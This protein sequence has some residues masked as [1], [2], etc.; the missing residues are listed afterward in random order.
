M[1]S[2]TT[3][4]LVLFANKEFSLASIQ[5][6]KRNANASPSFQHKMLGGNIQLQLFLNWS[7]K[8]FRPFI[9]YRV[10][11]DVSHEVGWEYRYGFYIENIPRD[12]SLLS[13]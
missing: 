5:N 10:N 8:F 7:P 11:F 3:I 2:K 6:I 13:P 9:F 4:D 1:L 12:S